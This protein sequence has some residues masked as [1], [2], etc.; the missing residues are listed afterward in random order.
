M[1][2]ADRHSELKYLRKKA[3]LERKYSKDVYAKAHLADFNKLDEKSMR[4]WT[5]IMSSNAT[6]AI[7][8]VDGKK[9]NCI[10]EA[11]I[12]DG[13]LTAK[14]LENFSTNLKLASERG[15]DSVL[16]R[17]NCNDDLEKLSAVFDTVRHNGMATI[18]VY[19]GKYIDKSWNPY[20][21]PKTL[22]EYIKFAASRSD[23]MLLSWKGMT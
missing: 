11:W 22:S 17:Y 2:K 13:K 10:A 8:H 16:V 12:R 6:S 19:C 7:L 23:M 9:F 20:A 21:D 18:C 4:D 3:R 14:D 1:P 5:Y 15:Y